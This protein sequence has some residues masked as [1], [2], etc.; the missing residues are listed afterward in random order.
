MYDY[1]Y[2]PKQFDIAYKKLSALAR[3]TGWIGVDT[4]FYR[5]H[6]YWPVLSLIQILCGKDIFIF[7]VILL[8]DKIPEL[9]TVFCDPNVTKIFHAGEQDLGILNKVF[10]STVEPVFDTQIAAKIFGFGYQMGYGNLIEECFKI[11][12]FKQDQFSEWLERPLTSRQL[13]YAALDVFY[14]GR[15]YNFLKN[16]PRETLN[17]LQKNLIG[18]QLNEINPASLMKKIKKKALNDRDSKILERFVVL[19][20]KIAQEEDIPRLRVVND[21][22][23]MLM[24]YKVTHPKNKLAL[25]GVRANVIKKWGDYILNFML[26]ERSLIEKERQTDG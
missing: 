26:E 4:E 18:I 9:K 7:D 16:V 20:E 14:F 1:I 3:E 6:T 10:K 17:A 23:L 11:T 15:L 8:K 12:L 19:R 22:N 2:D 24:L 21:K 13:C 5:V 25:H